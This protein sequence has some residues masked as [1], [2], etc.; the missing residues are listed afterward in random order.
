MSNIQS[1][2]QSLLLQARAIAAPEE[3][4]AFLDVACG[5]DHQLRVAVEEALQRSTPLTE[6]TESEA[7]NGPAATVDT[8]DFGPQE[9]AKGATSNPKSDDLSVGSQ[10]S[11]NDASSKKI[12]D[13]N[14]QRSD[15]AKERTRITESQKPAVVTSN[16]SVLTA[17]GRT[18]L[19]RTALGQTAL[20]LT[21][22]AKPVL[23]RESISDGEEPMVRP[24][25]EVP[26]SKAD[27]RYRIDGEIARGGMGVV[28][29]GRDI[30]LGRDLAIKVLLD[31]HSGDPEVIARFIEEAQVSGQLQ[32]PGIAPVYELGQFSDGRPFISMKLVKGRTLSALLVARKN[33]MQ[34][35]A[36][37]LGIFE[38]ICQAMAYAHSRGVIHRDLKPSN[39]MVGAFGEVQ[40]M[41][42]GLA[43]VLAEGGIEDERRDRDV[44]PE[45]SHIRTMRSS[46]GD[47]SGSY[48]SKTELGRVLGTP[49]YMPPEQATGD[50]DRLNERVDVFG[51]GAILCQ[52]LT[53]QPPY[54]GKVGSDIYWLAS[55][56]MMNDCQERLDACGAD[57][58]LLQIV[59]G[60]LQLD[61]EKRYRDASVVRDQIA[62]YL[63][64]VEKRLRDAEVGEAEQ[65]ARAEEAQLT[66]AA[67]DA[68][69]KAERR[70]S[71]LKLGLLSAVFGFTLLAALAATSYLRQQR[72]KNVV[73]SDAL[74]AKSDYLYV[75]HLQMTDEAWKTGAVRRVRELLR[76]HDPVVGE[77]DRRTFEWHYFDRLSRRLQ[78]DPEMDYGDIV[79][80]VA[81]SP[82]GEYTAVAGNDSE[83]Q[84]FDMRSYERVATLRGHEQ[85]VQQILI[86]ED[87]NQM[88]TADRNRLRIWQ[89]TNN[90]FVALVDEATSD[91]HLL[92]LSSRPA[93]LLS[94][95]DKLLNV[96]DLDEE[97]PTPRPLAFDASVVDLT[98]LVEGESL[99]VSTADGLVQKLGIASDSEP[100]TLLDLADPALSLAVS[101]DG[102]RVA[103]ATQTQTRVFRV[104]DGVD[105]ESELNLGQPDGVQRDL[106]SL[107]DSFLQVSDRS[108]SIYDFATGEL[109]GRI[110]VES[111]DTMSMTVVSDNGKSIAT[112]GLDN[113]VSI[114]DGRNGKQVGTVRGHDNV[115]YAAAFDPIGR[116]V[117]AGRD[118]LIRVSSQGE[119]SGPLA[120]RGHAGRIW[121]IAFSADA[122]VLASA[123]EDSNVILWDTSDGSEITRLTDHTESVQFVTFA[124]H[125]PILAT[126]GR[127]DTIKLWDSETYEMIG[128]CLGH[129]GD[130]NSLAF[131]EDGSCLVSGGDDG[132]VFVWDVDSRTA[133]GKYEMESG[134]VWA[135]AYGRDDRVVFGGTN[136]AVLSWDFRTEAEPESL[137]S[138]ESN[139]TSIDFS[140]DYQTLAFTS[141]NGSITL[142]DNKLGKESSRPTAHAGDAMFTA[143]SPDG[144]TLVSAGADGKVV[145]WYVEANEPT[146]TF[147]DHNAHVH[148]VAISPDGQM[149]ASGSWDSTVRL[150]KAD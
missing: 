25:P 95:T 11:M 46:S 60:C 112:F 76:Q 147:D 79:T 33:M 100:L 128:E 138:D 69:A 15:A 117:T 52:I 122:R 37:F 1:R 99:L 143:F 17:L 82:D 29:R 39:I 66:A 89:R 59:H 120:L 103:V 14:V 107:G 61:P 123:G 40:V 135:V 140:P 63:A 121:S 75:A 4:T 58:E 36:K 16:R 38:Q 21:M 141:G 22:N 88:V 34:D 32:H 85:K 124:P 126:S 45:T 93:T 98:W 149:V 130:V 106:I 86:S 94:V 146:I 23:L 132:V 65:A 12:H 119:G 51:L 43:K 104:K 53:G 47:T 90:E 8:K 19:G 71:R 137:Y 64:S 49:A 111:R 55:R 27:D 78:A 74:D 125:R 116:V 73:I 131:S 133:L 13:E 57:P 30:D 139:I 83:I 110:P 56:G 87:G 97:D 35:Q 70:A 24:S 2:L 9:D 26:E 72:A 41:D 148:C 62:G 144:R 84:I 10:V 18:A 102:N 7:F 3:R 54:V 42:W 96:W 136:Q 50:V 115:V 101:K 31:S 145:F 67:A 6:A 5:D 105:L 80:R 81:V 134:M 68:R 44:E 28:L 109:Q 129:T 118:Q 114:W 108:R 20:G 77:K 142:F 91:P 150:W 48:G 92:M 127:D 113:L